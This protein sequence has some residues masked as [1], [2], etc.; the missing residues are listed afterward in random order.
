MRLCNDIITVFNKR[1]NA[2]TGD[3]AYYPTIIKGVSWY[4][5]VVS[6]LSDRGLN[7]ANRF[8]VRVP[9]DADFGGSSYTDPI[10]YADAGDVSALFTFAMGDRVVK[11]AYSDDSD[12]PAPAD[13]SQE[14]ETPATRDA[15]G[16]NS[17]EPGENEQSGESGNGEGTGTEESATNQAFTLAQLDALYYEHFTVLGVTD[18]RRAPNAPHWRLVGS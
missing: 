10:S 6:N 15:V 16:D 11:G 14:E 3:Y 1:I 12:E 4:G 17:E 2:E 5:E 18:N 9:I 8:T 13:D 7:A